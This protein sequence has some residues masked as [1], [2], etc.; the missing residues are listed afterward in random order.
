MKISVLTPCYNE[1]GNIETCYKLVK[2]Q[3]EIL[4]QNKG[5]NYEHIFI[6][7]DSCDKTVEILERIALK[8]KT[9]K[10]I[11]NAKNVG[12]VRSCHYGLLQCKGDAVIF[13]EADLQTPSEM[14]P[15]FVSKW[16]EGFKIVAGVK[17]SS[18]ENPVMFF[19]RKLFYSTLSKF[20]ETQL[21]KD[22]LG[23]GLYDQTFIERLRTIDDPY[24]YFRG[25]V[26]DLGVDIAT[27]PYSQ[28]VR[29][30]GKSSFNLYRLFDIA[31]LG[32][33]N[34]TKLPIRL[35]TFVGIGMAFVCFLLA[36]WGIIYKLLNWDTFSVG[37]AGISVGLFFIASVQLIFLGIIG[38]YISAIFIQVRKRPLVIEKRRINF[39]NE[40]E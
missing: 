15:V 17:A 32:F 21:I 5:Y 25:M 6:D 28:N 12:F 14:I 19:I 9:V 10:V 20:S 1:E 36:L 2:E 24:P 11:V 16:E 7:N 33:V 4:S 40:G 31:M 37:L 27:V 34:Q 13:I 38:E 8:D 22:F 39:E 3:L 29:K 35:A 30:A 26:S 18:K 23:V